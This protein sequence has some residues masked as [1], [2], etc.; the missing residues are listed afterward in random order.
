VNV[1]LDTNILTR[2][3]NPEDKQHIEAVESLRKLRIAGHVP[4]LVPQNLYELWVVATRP[5]NANGL[6]LT[7][8]AVSVE[9][10]RL[11]APLFHLLQDERTILSRWRELVSTYQVSGKPAHDARLVAAMLRHGL[12][13]LITFNKGDFSRYSEVTAVHPGEVID[14]TAAFLIAK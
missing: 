5:M 13:C 10:D 8:N 3:I 12:S 6:G 2:W 11:K 7:P 1:L 4:T 9:L 14:G